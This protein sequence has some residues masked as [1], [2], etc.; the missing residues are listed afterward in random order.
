MK[1]PL[2]KDLSVTPGVFPTHRRRRRAMTSTSLD[3][4]HA[5]ETLRPMPWMACGSTGMS[6]GRYGYERVEGYAAIRKV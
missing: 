4:T 5:G 2:T 1:N 3:G 6:R